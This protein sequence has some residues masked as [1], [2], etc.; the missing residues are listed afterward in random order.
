MSVCP[1]DG[2]TLLLPVDMAVNGG[3][4]A[5]DSRPM[6]GHDAYGFEQQPHQQQFGGYHD[7]PQQQQQ[8]HFAPGLPHDAYDFAAQH[9]DGPPAQQPLGDWQPPAEPD[10]QPPFDGQPLDGRPGPPLPSMRRNGSFLDDRRGS[11]FEGGLPPLQGGM[12]RS[13]SFPH[14]RPP[15]GRPGFGDAR[16]GSR[17]GS[18]F[19]P[20]AGNMGPRPFPDGGYRDG[21]GGYP[22]QDPHFDAGDWDGPPAAGPIDPHAWPDERPQ[23]GASAGSG[24]GPGRAGVGDFCDR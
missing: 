18:P 24:A 13:G 6:M 23:I 7:G 16:G 22:P 5:M 8:Q 12:H 14:E 11:P 3:G 1:G 10:W 9:L 19:F 21:G 4:G 2:T 15:L 17:D 20:L